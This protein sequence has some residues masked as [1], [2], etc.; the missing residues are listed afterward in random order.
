MNR[1]SLPGAFVVA[2]EGRGELRDQYERYY[3]RFGTDDG[4]EETARLTV[5]PVETNVTTVLNG[6]QRRYARSGRNFLIDF[7]GERL[8]FDPE[9]RRF[10]CTAGFRIH[11]VVPI[12]E[13]EMRKELADENEAVLHASGVTYGGE[14]LIFPAWQRTGKTNALLTLLD[15]GGEY[16]ADDRLFVRSDGRARGYP[17]P[18]T[19]LSNNIQ[20]FADTF[21]EGRASILRSKAT[22]RIGRSVDARS[23]FI[24]RGIDALNERY[25]RQDRWV[26]PEEVFPTTSFAGTATADRI[27]L[28]RSDQSLAPGTVRRERID[29][30]DLV[31]AVRSINAFEFDN[32]LSDVGHAH[33]LLFPD[34]ESKTAE[35][36]EL[37]ASDAAVLA[38]VAERPDVSIHQLHLPVQATWDR[39]MKDALLEAIDRL[40]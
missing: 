33:D 9:W 22:E 11:T 18:T 7:Y 39:A 17:I 14:T 34:A 21:D 1:F 38:S 23:D 5:G 6:P 19:L 2:V 13:G 20:S 30:H 3:D 26:H 8:I 32:L 15:A 16:L 24:S 29:P 28:L 25:V 27:V 35:V 4:S 36:G 12:I 10:A 31:D 40:A 37:R